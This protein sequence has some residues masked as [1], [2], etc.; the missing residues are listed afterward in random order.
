METFQAIVVQSMHWSYDPMPWLAYPSLSYYM[1]Y[2]LMHILNWIELLDL[3]H[4]LPARAAED[5]KAKA[6]AKARVKPFPC[7][8]TDEDYFETRL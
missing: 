7:S 5:S 4:S 3:I 6:L 1:Q 8:Y 2:T